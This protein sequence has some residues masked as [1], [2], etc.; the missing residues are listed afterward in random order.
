MCL[1]SA[2]VLWKQQELCFASC[3]PFPRAVVSG[4]LG[5]LLAVMELWGNISLGPHRPDCCFL[6]LGGCSCAQGEPHCSSLHLCSK[7]T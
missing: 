1:G 5:V 4:Q 6:K 2:C 3:C 7:S